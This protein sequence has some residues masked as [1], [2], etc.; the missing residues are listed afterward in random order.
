MWEVAADVAKGERLPTPLCGDRLGRFKLLE[1]LERLDFD[2]SMNAEVM[3]NAGHK[4]GR[5]FEGIHFVK[6]SLHPPKDFSEVPPT[7]ETFPYSPIP[8]L[9]TVHTLESMS[10]TIAGIVVR[11]ESVHAGAYIEEVV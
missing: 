8:F 9:Q 10:M 1:H 2:P 3:K 4:G 7:A 6:H 5:G 11:A